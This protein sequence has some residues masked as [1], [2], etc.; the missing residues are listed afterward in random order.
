MAA[1]T[2][3]PPYLRINLKRDTGERLEKVRVYERETW[4][5]LVRRLLDERDQREEA[6]RDRRERKAS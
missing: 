2:T 3:L 6:R 4:D 1:E 5:D